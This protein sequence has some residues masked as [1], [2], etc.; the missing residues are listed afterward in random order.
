MKMNLPEEILSLIKIIGIQSDNEGISVYLVGGSCRDMVMDRTSSVYDIDIACEENAIEFAKKISKSL[1]GKV[2]TYETFKTATLFLS[3][4]ISK[5]YRGIKKIDFATLRK[6]KYPHTG[7]L[8]VVEVGSIEE[9][10]YR[11]DFTINA[12]AINISPSGFGEVI[13]FFGGRE[14]IDKKNIRVLHDKSFI[15]D[16]TR[17]FRAIKFEQRFDFKICSSTEMLIKS[18][19]ESKV[20]KIVNPIRIKKEMDLIYKEED[21]LKIIKRIKTFDGLEEFVAKHKE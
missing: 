4:E 18:A 12:L 20:L 16:P 19:I 8:P 6:E 9:D 17:I 15:D 3:D 10:M 5:K 13:D 2:S 11:R 7:A 21:S 1:N 14:D